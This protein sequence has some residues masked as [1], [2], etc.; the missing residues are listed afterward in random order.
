MKKFFSLLLCAS[1]GFAHQFVVSWDHQDYKIRF[2]ADGH[3]GSYQNQNVFGVW[4]KDGDGKKI[5]AGYDYQKNKLFFGA[6]PALI[7]LHY[8]FGY[9]SFDKDGKPYPQRRDRIQDKNGNAIT[10]TRK[11]YKLSKNILAWNDAFAKPIGMDLEIVP[12][13]NP[14][15][16]RENQELEVQVFYQGK[17]MGGLGFEDQVGDIK[18]LKTDE[19]GRA[20]IRLRKS[21]DGLQIIGVSVKKPQLDRFADTLQLTSTLSFSPAH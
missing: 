13:Q 5:K 7:A 6:K 10:Q 17:P 16:L 15:K 2:W 21:Q 20:K 18:S 3:W 4:A 14:L 9:Y 11:I 19:E 12:L 1:F 8:D